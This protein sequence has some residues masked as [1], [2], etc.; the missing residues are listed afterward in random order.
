M[1]CCEP[2]QRVRP[3][4]NR[5]PACSLTTAHCPGAAQ[6]QCI[7]NPL[8]R[9]HV[10]RTGT[11]FDHYSWIETRRCSPCAPP[12]RWTLQQ[13]REEAV[14]QRNC[15]REEAAQRRELWH[16]VQAKATGQLCQQSKV[17][18]IDSCV[19]MRDVIIY[20]SLLAAPTR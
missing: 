18:R 11:K 9:L 17:I 1:L 10:A 2:V 13:R 7:H 12:V 16:T 3:V 15:M 14:Q 20:F 6:S 5:S 19:I 8:T 4:R